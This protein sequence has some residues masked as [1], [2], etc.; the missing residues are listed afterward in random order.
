M[1]RIM[2]GIEVIVYT[3]EISILKLNP[4]TKK[5]ATVAAKPSR[6]LFVGAA[7]LRWENGSSELCVN[8]ACL[9]LLRFSKDHVDSCRRSEIR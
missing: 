3:N 1:A 7:A 2:R 6:L 9:Y 8:M 5:W 4:P